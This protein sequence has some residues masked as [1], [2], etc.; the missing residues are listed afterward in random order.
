[1]SCSIDGT[2]LSW[3]VDLRKHLLSLY[4]LPDGVTPIPQ[5]VLLP[6]KF[7]L[8]LEEEGSH[9]DETNNKSAMKEDSHDSHQPSELPSLAAQNLAVGEVSQTKTDDGPSKAS[10]NQTNMQGLN[11]SSKLL[12]GVTQ[13]NLGKQSLSDC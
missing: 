13:D 5:D 8:Q 1:M 10:I 12:R 7:V 6:P 9:V 2:L 11:N 4:P 3:S